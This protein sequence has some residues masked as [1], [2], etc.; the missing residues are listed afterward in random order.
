MA[1][2]PPDTSTIE[3]PPPPAPPHGAAGYRR[4]LG[5]PGV[6]P[7]AIASVLARLPIG[8][9]AIGLVLYV[10]HETGSFAAAGIAA[11]GF[12]VGVGLTAPFLGR[13][14]DS[15]G[16]APL[17]PAA[18]VSS[19]GLAAVVACGATGAATWTLVAGATVAGIGTPP[20]GGVFRHRLPDLI[21]SA[22]RPTAFAVDSILIEAFFIGGPLLAGGLAAT[23]G[24]AE[25]L[26]VAAVVGLVGTT[27]FT[28]LL[29]PHRRDA[30]TPR[31][32]GGALASPAIRVLVL[33]GLPI[34]ACF[35]ALDVALPAFGVAHGS[36]ALGGPYG[37]SIA[38]GSAIGGV[39]YGIRPRAFGPPRV[40][41]LRLAGLQALFV[42][43]LLLGPSVAAMFFLAALAG[44][45]IAPLISVRSELVGEA[46]P[47]GT[48]NEAFSWVSVSVAFGASAGSA[49]AGPVV[50]SG[51]WRLGIAIAC[52]APTTG[53]VL[54]FARRHII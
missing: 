25:A 50:E 3:P 45:C 36:A 22:D 47:P 44:I 38:F 8:M 27:W 40:A 46:I 31:P 14:V 30:V 53:F 34:G 19:L 26:I 49:I 17:V 42:L 29:P 12:T 15:H 51:G 10:R 11:A 20:I 39:F 52:I 54:L 21:A 48:G 4:V 37:A 24:P 23:A 41:I 7:L 5:A 13:F 9:S 28:L 32:R 33:A 6:L 1:T 16:R 35:G 18:V 2:T 43:P